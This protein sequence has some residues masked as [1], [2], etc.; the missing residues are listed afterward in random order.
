M[1][2]L[3]T[4]SQ[5]HDAYCK[6]SGLDPQKN[7]SILNRFRYM[8]K[9]GLLAGGTI[10]DERGTYAFPKIEVFR[11]SIY[12][13]LAGVAMDIRAFGPIGEAAARRHPDGLRVPSSMKRDGGF[14]SRGGLWDSIHGVAQGEN[15]TLLI[16][17]KRPGIST[18]GGMTAE[19]I[20]DDVA[21]TPGTSE[22]VDTILGRK[23]VRTRVSVDLGNLFRPL[24]A[25]VGVPA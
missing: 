3:Y 7:P 6:A 9:R 21:T 5:M 14:Y 1:P 24:I 23:Q 18:E 16:E 19:F 13:E 4:A 22:A 10:I 17:L 8:A 11:A 15:W 12:T 25:I 20:C 2:D